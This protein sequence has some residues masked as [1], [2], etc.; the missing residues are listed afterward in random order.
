MIGSVPEVLIKT[1][2]SSYKPRETS[3]GLLQ[4][5]KILQI[6]STKTSE[7]INFA[8]SYQSK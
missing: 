8:V 5:L 1:V 2:A 6:S 7:F 3:I 4:Q